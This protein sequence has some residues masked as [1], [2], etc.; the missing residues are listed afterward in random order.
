MSKCWKVEVKNLVKLIQNSNL[1]K[2][3]RDQIQG[4]KITST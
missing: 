4:K 1:S 2:G 3:D